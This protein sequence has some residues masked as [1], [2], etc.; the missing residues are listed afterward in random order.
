MQKIKVKFFDKEVYPEGLQKIGGKKSDWIDLRASVDVD[1]KQGDLVYIPLG[2]AMQLPE[3]YE[4]LVAPRSSMPKNYL[5]MQANSIGIID[6]TFCGDNDEWKLPAYAIRDT[7]IKK[8][9]R[10]CQF[11]IIEHQPEINFEICDLL[12]NKDRGGWGSSGK[13]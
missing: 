8:G 3:G 5:I 13:K 9:E 2:V 11:R 10:V 6:E 12:G 4:A 1:M 7:Q